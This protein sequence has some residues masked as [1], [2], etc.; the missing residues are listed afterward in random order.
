ME[1][2]KDYNSVQ[3][4]KIFGQYI[5][6]GLLIA[7]SIQTFITGKIVSSILFM[8]C[9][10]YLLPLFSSKWKELIPSLNDWI[11]RRIV[12]IILFFIALYFRL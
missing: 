10:I 7:L 2:S 8:I 12:F 9:A 6:G 5:V 11:W 4:L 3:V 1:N